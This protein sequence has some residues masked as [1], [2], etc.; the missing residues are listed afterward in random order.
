MN[1]VLYYRRLNKDCSSLSSNGTF[2]FEN[3]VF[4]LER[5]S[6]LTLMVPRVWRITVTSGGSPRRFSRVGVGGVGSFETWYQ[7][8]A[9]SSEEDSS[10]NTETSKNKIRFTLEGLEVEY[11]DNSYDSYD[12]STYTD[13]E[14]VDADYGEFGIFEESEGVM[15]NIQRGGYHH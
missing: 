3:G 12:G 11:E 4:N 2:A 6:L 7:I 9:D 10:G 13:S 8:D 15:A 1:H 5:Q 14:T